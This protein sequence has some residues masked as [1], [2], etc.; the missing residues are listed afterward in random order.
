MVYRFGFFGEWV[1][2][3]DVGICVMD[4]VVVDFDEYF[5]SKGY[6]CFD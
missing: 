5:V 3:I 6:V 1:E 2:I 4:L